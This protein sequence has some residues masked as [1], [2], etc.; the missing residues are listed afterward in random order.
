M[1]QTNGPSTVLVVT[2]GEPVRPSCRPVLPAADVVVAADSGLDHAALLGLRADVVVGDFDSVDPATLARAEAAGAVVHRHPVA[3]EATDLELALRVAAG[4]G[5]QRVVVTGGAGG[6]FDH[7]LANVLLLCADDFAGVDVEAWVGPAHLTVVRTSCRL[8]GS[9]GD[10]VSLLPVGGPARGVR[11]EGLRYPL[12]DEDL[13]AGTSRG[14]SNELVGTEARVTLR[15]GV[16]LA[17]QPGA[18]P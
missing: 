9:P 17:V 4:F 5:P 11:T 16:L 3:K 13:A 6:R 1:V 2:G 14:V 12:R 10:L 7:E 15:S 18:C 8:L